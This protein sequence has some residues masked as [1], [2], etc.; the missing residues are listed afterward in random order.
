MNLEERLA[1]LERRIVAIEGYMWKRGGLGKAVREMV[2]KWPG[3]FTAKQI[4][5]A[6]YEVHPEL[7]PAKEYG[8]VS[9]I[10]QRL[11][12]QQLIT[13]TFRGAGPNPNIYE[14]NTNPPLGAGVKGMKTNTHRDNESGFRGIVRSALDEL[15]AEWTIN[16]LRAWVA[17]K[18]PDAV[19]PYGSWSST[20]YKLTQSKELVVVRGGGRGRG[21]ALKVYGRG[22]RRITPSGEELRDLEKSWQDFRATIKTE[23]VADML[24]SAQQRAEDGTLRID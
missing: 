11:V 6:V 23:P 18:A 2:D 24:M 3:P 7:R 20:L 5:A 1:E 14:R 9:T 12:K 16:E 21:S 19:I 8:Q 22:P 17:L 13:E 10:M 15:P 4:T